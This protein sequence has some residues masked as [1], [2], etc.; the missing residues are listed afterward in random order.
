[1]KAVDVCCGLGGSSDGLAEAGFKII[2]IE[3][4]PHICELYK[5]PVINADIR[6][7]PGKWFRGYDLIWA[8]PPCRDFSR[9]NRFKHWKEPADPEGKGLELVKACLQF[10]EDA[11]PKYWILENVMGL[12]K[13]LGEAPRCRAR[14]S[15]TM[16]RGFWGN[17][18]AFLIPKSLS[19]R[20][21]WDIQ[22]P[23]RKWERAKIPTCVSKA[24]GEGIMAEFTNIGDKE[25]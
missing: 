23:L 9:M 6:E 7:I 18:P 3:I 19:K 4:E 10:I 25:E 24:L 11:Q 13:Y 5:H 15:K 14:L 16:I 21:I 12:E 1:M 8:S 22:G 20:N 2:G 17:F